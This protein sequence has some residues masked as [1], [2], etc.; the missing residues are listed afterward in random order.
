VVFGERQK[1]GEGGFEG[2]KHRDGED[3]RVLAVKVLERLEKEGW[4]GG[5]LDWLGVGR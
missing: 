4:D 2:E 5:G 1:E 3:R